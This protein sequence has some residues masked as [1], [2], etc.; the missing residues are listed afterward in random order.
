MRRLTRLST[1]C[2]AVDLHAGYAVVPDPGAPYDL[3]LVPTRRITG[4]EDPRLQE[5][6]APNYWRFAWAARV[7]LAARRHAALPREGVA[8]AVNALPGRSQDQLHIHLSCVRPDVAH[9]LL[10][11]AP[12]LGDD[13]TSVQ[14]AGRLWRV[15]LVHGEDLTDAD[16]FKML[17]AT[18]PASRADMEQETLVVVGAQLPGGQP[19]FY[20]LN[21]AAD[22]ETGYNGHGEFLLDERCAGDR[23]PT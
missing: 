11:A 10:A 14:I 3:L 6:G 17:A 15:K 19:G 20:V 4:I 16:P 5:T 1:P 13:W 8:M 2:V 9:D 12:S 7:R 23:H 22:R 21:R 18:D